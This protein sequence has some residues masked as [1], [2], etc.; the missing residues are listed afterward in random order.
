M[1]YQLIVTINQNQERMGVYTLVSLIVACLLVLFGVD[2]FFVMA[3][4]IWCVSFFYA[5]SDFRH[6]MLYTAFL[7]SFFVFLLSGRLTTCPLIF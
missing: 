3:F 4:S 2:V 7:I 5:L 6:R 1:V